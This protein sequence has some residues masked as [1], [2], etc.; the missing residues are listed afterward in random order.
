MFD[1]GYSQLVYYN[2]LMSKLYTMANPTVVMSQDAIVRK[3]K[4]HGIRYDNISYII[5]SHGHPDHIGGLQDLRAKRIIT[6]KEV[7]KTMLDSKLRDVVFKNMI[8][9]GLEYDV[10]GSSD[11]VNSDN[12]PGDFERVYDI[13]GDGSL[14]GI[15]LDGHAKGQLGL[16]IPERHLLLAADASWGMKFVRYTHRMRLPARLIQNDFSAYCRTQRKISRM[17]D[18]DY[19]VKV[20]YSHDINKDMVL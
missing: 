12:V 2:G 17:Q 20:I 9:D 14:Y 8:P 19:R 7:K 5:I 18:E 1:T 16:Y 15:V 10:L 13:L 11:R 4:A 3:L 6:T